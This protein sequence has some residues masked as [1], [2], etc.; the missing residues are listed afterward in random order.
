MSD[1]WGQPDSVLARR[2]SV[3]L[4]RPGGVVEATLWDICG[5][6]EQEGGQHW[7]SLEV[8]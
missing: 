2:V 1:L 4:G 7:L 3:S 6:S 5:A 8:A